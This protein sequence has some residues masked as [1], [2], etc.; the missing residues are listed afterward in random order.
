MCE[1][2]QCKH[3][4]TEVAADDDNGDRE[5]REVQSASVIVYISCD[6]VTGMVQINKLV[7][8]LI[9]LSYG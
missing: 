1:E 5:K 7:D 2:K 4:K 9:V 8:K 3:I 6:L